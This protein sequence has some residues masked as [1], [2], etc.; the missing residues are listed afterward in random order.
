MP[1]HSG[2]SIV[3]QE[4][5]FDIAP[6]GLRKCIIST[7]I[8]E[9]SVTIDGI[10]FI[11][12]SGKVKELNYDSTGGF[13]RLSEFWISKSSATQRTGR[14]GRTGPG[15]CFRMYT[16]EEFEGMNEFPVPE[17]FRTS[18]DSMFL[19]MKALGFGDPRRFDYIECPS[20]QSLESSITRLMHLGCLDGRERLT[21]LGTFLSTLPIEPTL[22][23]FIV[24]GSVS[25]LSSQIITLAAV[26]SVQSPLVRIA[27]SDSGILERRR[28]YLSNYGDPFTLLNLLN[29]WLQQK[30][31]D[32]LSSRNWCKSR[33]VEEQRFYE[34]I[35]LKHQFSESFSKQLGNLETFHQEE[36]V[37][38]DEKEK[39]KIKRLL[40]KK[41][42]EQGS[43]KRKFLRIEQ[44]DAEEEPEMMIHELEFEL[45]QN[46]N[47][48]KMET[49]TSLLLEKDINV[50][51]LILVA[52][53]YPN[54]AIPDDSNYS[55]PVHERVFHTA[56]KR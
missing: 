56:G 36:E 20:G 12:D 29:G 35:K 25:N 15:K 48:L 41:K 8:A 40:A 19:Q 23:K 51:R 30:S 43:S 3:D 45:L 9:T 28:E 22:G 44:E 55:R 39:R 31:E 2:L 7:N 46:P 26:L 4:K 47:K 5:V 49:Q 24:L 14:A 42:E 1:L 53:F 33:G 21:P 17:I 32:P 11:I 10:R 27:G 16:K 52:G 34:I 13:S 18:L 54:V 50:I 6:P 37:E 38:V